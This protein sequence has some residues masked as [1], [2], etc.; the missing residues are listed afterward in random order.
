[1]NADKTALAAAVVGGYVL[2][3]TKKGKLAV[4]AVTYLVGRRLGGPRQ[5]AAEG[6]RRIGEVPQ[7]ADLGQQIRNEGLDAARNAV[8][9][10]AGRRVGALADK[11]SSRAAGLAGKDQGD[12]GDEDE[13]RDAEGETDGEEPDEEPEDDRDEEAYEEPPRHHRRG[14]NSE[15]RAPAKK[16]AKKAVPAKKAAAKKTAPEPGKPPRNAPQRGE[17]RR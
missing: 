1:M 7:V 14:R 12:E 4:T 11:V 5:L 9:A 15:T 3:R 10:V 8:T 13:P 17:R 2:G 16:T 6:M